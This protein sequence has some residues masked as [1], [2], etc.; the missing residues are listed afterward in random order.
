MSLRAGV[1]TLCILGALIALGLMVRTRRDAGAPGPPTAPASPTATPASIRIT[2]RAV[3]RPTVGPI[4]APRPKASATTSPTPA[5]TATPTPEPARPD[6]VALG[7]APKVKTLPEPRP[8]AT[9]L[10]PSATAT[11]KPKPKAPGGRSL[12]VRVRGPQDRP[13]AGAQIAAVWSQGGKQFRVQ[14]R[15]DGQGLYEAAEAT[16]SKIATLIVEAQ[17]FVPVRVENI[18][19]NI[20][21]AGPVVVRMKRLPA[22]RGKVLGPD[23]QP[24]A[25]PFTVMLL[26]AR[27]TQD[28][29]APTLDLGAERPVV[30]ASERFSRTEGGFEFVKVPPGDYY[31]MAWASPNLG[32][33]SAPFTLKI[34]QP[35]EPR[36]VRLT[37][38]ASVG[39]SVTIEEPGGAATPG[40]GVRIAAVHLAARLGKADFGERA[41]RADAQ[42]RYALEG[43]A[44]GLY[45]IAAEAEANAIEKRA[46]PAVPVGKGQSAQVDFVLPRKPIRL[47]GSVHDELDQPLTN[48]S[49]L[50]L[51]S[52]PNPLEQRT[53]SDAQGRFEFPDLSAGVYHLGL[54]HPRDSTRQKMLRIQLQDSG[55]ANLPKPVRFYARKQIVGHVLRRGA[56]SGVTS[57]RFVWKRDPAFALAGGAIEAP[58]DPLT[59]AYE[60]LLE[61][62]LYEVSA[63]GSPPQTYAVQAEGAEAF[64]LDLRLP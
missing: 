14:G 53:R 9:A 26:S 46:R 7:P 3:A 29:P 56:P 33:L 16:G 48:V 55:V 34:G 49:I 13:V 62:G 2:P 63:G 23:N 20:V 39:G 45:E 31:A 12:R 43:L 57:I 32:G 28:A 4:R 61:P 21:K 25:M 18:A 40:Q 60:T 52:A 10:A 44:G 36:T 15:T 59:G 42:G 5:P 6:V 47:R 27:E 24:F 17:G 41:T 19:E 51:R 38:Q 8:A 11:P 1:L 58:V 30:A 64:R 35:S 37:S 54:V 50:L 22:V